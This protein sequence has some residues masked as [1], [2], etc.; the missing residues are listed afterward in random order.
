MYVSVYIHRRNSLP[1]LYELIPSL[2]VSLY[3]QKVFL[4][5]IYILSQPNF[6]DTVWNFH[7]G[8]SARACLC[9]CARVRALVCVR[10]RMFVCVCVCARARARA[11]VYEGESITFCNLFFLTFIVPFAETLQVHNFHISPLAFQCTWYVVAHRL[12]A[13]GINIL[14]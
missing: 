9:V 2:C 8:M 13:L 14:V 5:I 6:R 7:D 12:Y 11:C 10:A 3:A 1:Y 4:T